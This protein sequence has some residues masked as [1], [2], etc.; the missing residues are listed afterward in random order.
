M[1]G[2]TVRVLVGLD[3]ATR[4]GWARWEEGTWSTGVLDCTPE[5]KDEPDGMR[6]ARFADRLPPLLRGVDAVLMEQPF[7]RG[8]RTAQVLG[9]LIAVALVECERA[10]VE[11]VF[12]HP[13]EA[14]AAATGKGRASKDE[15]I[16]GVERLTGLVG[17]SHDEADAV[18][19]ILHAL[20]HLMVGSS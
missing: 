9:G 2:P 12:V 17:L 14:K 16:A 4:T 1:E 5:V 20:E 6:F 7:S 11:Y 3:I 10:R 13:A 19:V 18:A 15:V 8:A